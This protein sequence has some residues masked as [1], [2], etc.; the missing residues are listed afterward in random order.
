MSDDHDD[1]QQMAVALRRYEIIGRYLALD[2]LRGQRRKV[3]EQLSAQ[4]WL[5]PDG[6]PLQVAPDTL[7]VW[8]RRYRTG[9]LGALKDKPRTHRGVGVLSAEQCELVAQLKQD[10][11]ERSLER[12]ITIAEEMKL[13]EPGVLRRSTVHRVL[14][15]RGVSA[16]KARVPDAQDLDR[17]EAAFPND[18]WQ[19]DLLPGVWLPD[20]QRR[21]KFRSNGSASYLEWLDDVLQLAPAARDLKLVVPTGF[22]FKLVDSPHE[23]LAEVQAKNA[24]KSN[25]ARLLAG[26]CWKWSDPLPDG[27]VDDIQIGDFRFPWESKNG[28]RPPPGIPEAKH[29]AI[30]PAGVG[31]AGTV[32]SVQGFEMDHVGVIIGPD[33]VMRDGKWIA[34]PAKNYS[35]SLRRKTPEIALPY[36][37]RIYRTLLSRPTQSCSVYCCDEE[38][39]KYLADRIIRP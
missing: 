3:L 22:N 39:K 21:G 8:I 30:D 37:K 7:R 11:P 16:R 32:Y 17:F 24:A 35:N 13:V 36:I 14:Q 28:K 15:S 4:T 27:L 19:S 9:G 20:P 26:W 38:T 6:A 2:P 5:S 31:Q 34:A 12:V 10:V 23:L 29:W 25:T 18:L 33:L 1:D